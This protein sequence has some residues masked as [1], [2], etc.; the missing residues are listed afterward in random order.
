MS[1]SLAQILSQSRC[2]LICLNIVSKQR[3][4]SNLV[5]MPSR[6]VSELGFQGLEIESKLLFSRGRSLTL[7]LPPSDSQRTLGCH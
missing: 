3:N 4:T 5:T 7:L 1:Y 2:G 6:A